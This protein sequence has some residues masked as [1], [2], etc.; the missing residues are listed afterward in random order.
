TTQQPFLFANLKSVPQK[1]M[2]GPWTHS[3]GYGGK[4]HDSEVLR[5]YDYW[6]KGVENG[7]MDEEPVHY[8]VMKGNNTVPPQV[9]SS[10]GTGENAGEAEAAPARS[11]DENESENGS[12]W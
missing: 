8:Y 10:T 9:A 1:M 5:W 3:G 2:I 7:I 12:A 6:L 4:V 11:L